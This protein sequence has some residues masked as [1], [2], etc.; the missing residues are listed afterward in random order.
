MN[1]GACVD[2]ECVKMGILMDATGSMGG[3]INKAKSSVVEMFK[4]IS[5]ILKHNKCDPK[6]FQIQFVAYRNYNAPE[7]ELL[8]YSGWTDDPLILNNFLNGVSAS[9]GI[10]N[11]AIEVALQYINQD[12]SVTEM[13]LIGDVCANT[14]AEVKSGRDSYNG[15]ETYWQKTKFNQ[16]TYFEDE[17]VKLKNKNKGIKINCFYLTQSAQKDFKKIANETN[18]EVNFLDV[19]GSDGA[20]IL[21]ALV[22]KKVLN[23]AGGD[24]NGKKYQDDY[25]KFFNKVHV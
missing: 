20:E 13:I 3:F 11:E 6:C 19:N 15:G 8:K 22:S 12:E 2:I 17:I 4:R 14:R 10:G 25:D 9:Y 18:G 1:C 24:Q 5:A 21:T 16:A 23:A 7:S